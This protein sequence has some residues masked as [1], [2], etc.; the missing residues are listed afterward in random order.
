MASSPPEIHS[1]LSTDFDRLL[2]IISDFSWVP[3]I[4]VF[5]DACLDNPCH[6]KCLNIEG[7]YFKSFSKFSLSNF[8]IAHFTKMTDG[9]A[10]KYYRKTVLDIGAHVIPHIYFW[11]TSGHVSSPEF[12]N[13][14]CI[15]RMSVLRRRILL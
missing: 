5:R 12:H 2:E 6:H 14:K 1:F 11:M 10:F 8:L 4:C 3:Q 13:R 7:K 15:L 9:M